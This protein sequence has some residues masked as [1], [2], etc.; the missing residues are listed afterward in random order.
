MDRLPQDAGATRR[1]LPLRRWPPRSPVPGPAG[2]G[3]GGLSNCPRRLQAAR[4]TLWFVD[5]EQYEG[6]RAVASL[7]SDVEAHLS[8]VDLRCAFC[9][10][11]VVVR[12]APERCPMCG[13]S[14]W[15]HASQPAA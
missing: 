4:G 15:E 6:D 9:G 8:V 1:L 11:G 13:G 10:Y 5:P 14:V 3:R 12:M 2:E 7:R